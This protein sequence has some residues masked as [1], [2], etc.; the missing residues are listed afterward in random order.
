[1]QTSDFA[2]IQVFLEKMDP[3]DEKVQGGLGVNE[4][5]TELFWAAL[6]AVTEETGLAIP[7]FLK[8][9]AKLIRFP[10]TYI[11]KLHQMGLIEHGDGRGQWKITAKAIKKMN[12]LL[13]GEAMVE[14]APIEPRSRKP[15]KVASTKV[16]RR[17]AKKT[18]G[19]LIEKLEGRARQ[20]DDDI[21]RLV[22]ERDGIKSKIQSI[23]EMFE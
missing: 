13:S 10:S 14:E 23:L 9:A 16:P 5:H 18:V 15:E 7:N 8:L 12:A 17:I 1:V 4:R 6:N 3:K 22:E 21:K 11:T 2:T 19:D 20:L